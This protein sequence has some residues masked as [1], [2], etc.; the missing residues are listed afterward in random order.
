[1]LDAEKPIINIDDL[2]STTGVNRMLSSASFDTSVGRFQFDDIA[3][4]HVAATFDGGNQWTVS[5]DPVPDVSDPSGYRPGVCDLARLV[6]VTQT[7]R[8]YTETT[9]GYYKLPF[10]VTVRFK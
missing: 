9:V 4:C 2:A 10:K 3:G 6:K 5:T 7:K 8:E 1:M